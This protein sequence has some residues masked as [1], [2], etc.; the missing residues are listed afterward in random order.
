MNSEYK[1]ALKLS[2]PELPCAGAS[3]ATMV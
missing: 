3:K 1:I 2:L